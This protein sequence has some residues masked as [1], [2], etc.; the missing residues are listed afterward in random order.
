MIFRIENKY[1][2]F[3]SEIFFKCKKRNLVE[4]IVYFLLIALCLLFGYL[5]LKFNSVKL[6]N[7]VYF[8]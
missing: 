1:D 5:L 7:L 6:L 3:E 8:V 4:T 2:K